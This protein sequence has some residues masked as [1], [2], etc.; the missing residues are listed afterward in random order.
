MDEREEARRLVDRLGLPPDATSL[1]FHR[2][3]YRNP[4]FSTRQRSAIAALQFE[5]PKLAISAV[6]DEKSLAYRLDRT[7]E[8]TEKVKRGEFVGNGTKLIEAKAVRPTKLRW[9]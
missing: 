4:A 3:V 9:L 7:L 6:I 1:D 2:A 5:H 8:R